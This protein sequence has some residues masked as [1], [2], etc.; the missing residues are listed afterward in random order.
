MNL[1]RSTCFAVLGL[2]F[3]LQGGEDYNFFMIADTHLGTAK[4]VDLFKFIFL[5]L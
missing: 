1:K 5:T 4:H 2:V 3:L